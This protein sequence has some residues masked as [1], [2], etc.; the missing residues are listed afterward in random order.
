MLQ[1][2]L[3]GEPVDG[4][5]LLL[6]LCGT[7]HHADITLPGPPWAGSYE[8]LWDSAQERPRPCAEPVSGVQRVAASSLRLYRAL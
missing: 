7:A 8:L 6:V 3:H 1:A 5:S 2:F 4:E